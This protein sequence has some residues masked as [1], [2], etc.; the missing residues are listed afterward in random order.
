LIQE[1][2]HEQQ[3]EQQECAANALQEELAAEEGVNSLER[4][5]EVEEE[6]KD[7]IN[8]LPKSNAKTPCCSCLCLPRSRS[9]SRPTTLEAQDELNHLPKSNA[10]TPCCSCLCLPS[11]HSKSRPTTRDVKGMNGDVSKQ[12]Q[13]APPTQADT[14][15]TPSTSTPSARTDSTVSEG[16]KGDV[17]EH[18]QNTQV[19]K[20]KSPC[21]GCMPCSR[22]AVPHIGSKDRKKAHCCRC[23]P[24]SRRDVPQSGTEEKTPNMR[25]D[26]RDMNQDISKQEK[27]PNMRQDSRDMDQD[28]SKQEKTPKMQQDEIVIISEVV[29]QKRKS[30]T[31]TCGICIPCFRQDRRKPAIVNPSAPAKSTT[32]TCCGRCRP[33]FRSETTPVQPVCVC[34]ACMQELEELKS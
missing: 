33:C 24:C 3:H 7:E 6:A 10:K 30:K 5:S 8:H 21:C 18:K 28:I 22:R 26:S 11:S 34:D 19:D 27:T 9:N 25:Q 4:I 13:S 17:S 2:Q 15:A 20:K 1:Q 23:M 12:E 14:T 32:T 31:P 16:M 29:S